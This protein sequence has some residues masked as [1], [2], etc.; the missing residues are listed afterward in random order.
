MKG[1]FSVTLIISRLRLLTAHYIVPFCSMFRIFRLLP[2]QLI[3]SYLAVTQ[4]HGGFRNLLRVRKSKFS[5][6]MYMSD[7]IL[8]AT[9]N[10]KK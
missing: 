9:K 1:E 6:L 3:S 2:P 10:E 5:S 4:R 7:I 8:C